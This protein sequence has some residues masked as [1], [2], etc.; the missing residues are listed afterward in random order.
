MNAWV[1]G[2]SGAWGGAVALELLRR[3][4]DV[5]ALGRHDAPA[6]AA[7]ATRLG[8]RWS[9]V[10]LDLSKVGAVP[11]E[12]APEVLVHCAVSTA[13][14]R[15]ALVRANFVTPAGLIDAV[16]VAMRRRGDG[17]IGVFMAQNAR[18]GLAGLGDYSAAQGALWTW[19]EAMQDELARGGDRVTLTRVIPPRTAS[20]A[21]RFVTERSGRSA[22]LHEPNAGPL[23]RAILAGKRRAGRR[24]LVVALA[25]A[26]RG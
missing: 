11:V 26:V 22:R 1:T 24:P 18:L 19:C 23:V 21:Q 16:A 17:R 15:D 25:M 20:A 7:W 8:R 4:Y 3:G 5:T 9:F 6:L 12:E 13:G 2:A 10:P 14:D